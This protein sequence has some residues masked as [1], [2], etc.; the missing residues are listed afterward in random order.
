[1]F[2][3]L[4]PASSFNMGNFTTANL[5]KK[6]SFGDPVSR[7]AGDHHGPID[8]ATSVLPSDSTSM[9][10]FA[11]T[12]DFGLSMKSCSKD[13]VV[14]SPSSPLLYRALSK[15]HSTDPKWSSP[16][17]SVGKYCGL[18][19]DKIQKYKCW[20]M[21]GKA[22]EAFQLLGPKILSTLNDNS[23]LKPSLQVVV[24]SAFMIGKEPTKAIPYVMFMCTKIGPRKK[25]VDAVKKS[26]LL[27]E[28]PGFRVG[29]WEHP[30]HT[31]DH[32]PLGSYSKLTLEA[33][34]RDTIPTFYTRSKS[35]TILQF[36][37]ENASGEVRKATVGGIVGYQGQTFLVSVSHV[38]AEQ[39]GSKLD[40]EGSDENEDSGELEVDDVDDFVFEG[41]SDDDNDNDDECY[42]FDDNG[43]ATSSS[44]RSNFEF[45]DGEHTSSSSR[46]IGLKDSSIYSPSTLSDASMSRNRTGMRLRPETSEPN[47]RRSLG[48]PKEESPNTAPAIMHL[49]ST[50]LDYVLLS[51]PSMKS[52]SKLPLLPLLNSESVAEAPKGDTRIKTITG[53]SGEL[54]GCL[55]GSPSYIRLGNSSR[56]QKCFMV[57]TDGPIFP[58]DSGSMII[59]AVTTDVYG[60]IVV[61]SVESRTAYIIP[62]VDVLRDLAARDNQIKGLEANVYAASA[63][64]HCSQGI[65]PHVNPTRESALAPLLT[66]IEELSHDGHQVSFWPDIRRKYNSSNPWHSAEHLPFHSAINSFANWV[67]DIDHL[68]DAR[69]R[70]RKMRDQNLEID[71]PIPT[72]THKYQLPSSESLDKKREP[73]EKIACQRG[74]MDIELPPP[75]SSENDD[76]SPTR[77]KVAISKSPYKRPKHERVFCRLC[78]NYPEGFRGEHEHR[79]HV[80]REHKSLVKRWVCVEPS[81]SNNSLK[82]VIPLSRCK[83]CRQKKTYRAYYNAAAHLRRTHFRPKPKHSKSKNRNL[84]ENN[85]KRDGYLAIADPPIAELKNNWMK[86]V[87]VLVDGLRDAPSEE[88]DAD[89]DAFSDFLDEQSMQPMNP[90][91][92]SGFVPPAENMESGSASIFSF[93]SLAMPFEYDGMDIGLPAVPPKSSAVMEDEYMTGSHD[94][95]A[96][97]LMY[98]LT[99]NSTG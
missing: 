76:D 64:N 49:S 14:E 79:R 91:S 81:D 33:A 58:G 90:F 73:L 98:D 3:L 56:Y 37:V 84:S 27:K 36:C 9:P 47:T 55:S 82:P 54:A 4:P 74:E 80:D 44:D 12:S 53:T 1:M 77:D 6:P 93:S 41:F 65:S 5:S 59:D 95:A 50:E 45:V 11:P 52:F 96:Y 24:W 87:E 83:A 51:P 63:S 68:M 35:Q 8:V 32:Y 31:G 20:E 99:E 94:G 46:S 97:S 22:E 30:P 88:A 92:D 67:E 85:D 21:K 70:Q 61:G 69:D 62:A 28:Y 7:L 48:N 89:D 66:G 78:D 86:L 17:E 2:D 19:E 43:S 23:T 29:H 60:H 10:K 72:T 38:L 16:E 13:T 42:D 39:F 15:L 34:V 57:T 18:H 25:A 75:G 40:D 26:G 71:H